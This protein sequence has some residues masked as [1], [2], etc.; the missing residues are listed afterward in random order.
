MSD[1][2]QFFGPSYTRP[3]ANIQIQ[4]ERTVNWR[5]EPIPGGREKSK[6]ALLRQP[7]LK[8]FSNPGIGGKVRGMYSLNGHLFVV[9]GS[10]F[11]E[12]FS[13]GTFNDISVLSGVFVTDDGL[14]AW[15]VSNENQVFVVSGGNGY[16]VEGGFIH[17]IASP[18]FPQ[19]HAAAAE[20][21]DGFFIV[22]INTVS[23]FTPPTPSQFM[24][25]SLNDGNLWN[26]ADVSSVESRPDFIVAPIQLR[27]EMWFFG[28][29]TIQPFYDSG[30]TLFPIVPN[31]SAVINAG[32]MA[33]QSV[34]RIGNTLYWLEID[35]TG[36]GTFCRNEGYA[37]INLSNSAL[38][39][40]WN[41]YLNLDQTYCWTYQEN[42]HACVR[43]N[44]PNIDGAGTSRTW[45]FD[46]LP[47]QWTETPY[48]NSVTGMEEAHRVFCSAV[49]FDKII[50][51]DRANGKL[52]ELNS[53]FFDD[54]GATIRR[55]RR[56]PHLYNEKRRITY[57][58]VEFDGN[59]GIGTI[60]VP[61]PSCIF[62]ISKD[63]GES[64]GNDITLYPGRA[65]DKNKRMFRAG[66]G[67]A[68]DAVMEL[69][70]TDAVD[71]AFSAARLDFKIGTS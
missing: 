2:T 49:C 34:C 64:F 46:D 21:L 56:T 48:W 35:E 22:T 26:A 31:Q 20:Y 65:G 29:L 19:G 45:E 15:I 25:S 44:F 55:V 50:V 30:D 32:C 27:E 16:I 62:H 11:L 52:Y 12:I 14:K 68:R 61:N 6:F 24:I 54:D 10:H 70:C 3:S 13:D 38:E 9:I 4:S 58:R 40:V 47:N 8:L 17:L 36:H 59:A 60:A 23:P 5:L 57:N 67:S 51:G 63:G 69:V 37:K 66:C 39:S 41:T 7:G 43:V 1:F 53:S 28:S 33:A 18:D 42:G 71:W